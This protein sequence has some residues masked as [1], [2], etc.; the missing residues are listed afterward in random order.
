MVTAKRATAYWSTWCV[1]TK[2]KN[3]QLQVVCC[4]DKPTT[5]LSPSNDAMGARRPLGPAVVSGL[6]GAEAEAP[7]CR[8]CIEVWQSVWQSVCV[9]KGREPAAER[10]RTP[11]RWRCVY[12]G[13][14][15][16]LLLLL[17]FQLPAGLK[18]LCVSVVVVVQYGERQ[19]ERTCVSVGEQRAG[20]RSSSY[21]VLWPGWRV[22]TFLCAS[23]DMCVL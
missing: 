19:T 9:C 13:T 10:A 4:A 6:V 23:S 17:L 5:L 11:S 21:S 12:L 15:S 1:L 22:L 14:A 7:W 18:K 8:P 3:N 20:R 2:T 16:L